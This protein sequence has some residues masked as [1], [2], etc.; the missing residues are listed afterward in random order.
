M[1]GFSSRMAASGDSGEMEGTMEKRYVDANVLEDLS[2][3]HARAQD[4]LQDLLRTAESGM[5]GAPQGGWDQGAWWEVRTTMGSELSL[6]DQDRWV[7]ADRAGRVRTVAAEG[8][9]P[10]LK[11]LWAAIAGVRQRIE[12]TVA[13]LREFWDNYKR[14]RRR[15]VLPNPLP[16]LQSG[17]GATMG[18]LTGLALTW[19]WKEALGILVPA[20]PQGK[21]PAVQPDDEA[22]EASVITATIKARSVSEGLV[23]WARDQEGKSVDADGYYGPQ[24][25][26]LVKGAVGSLAGGPLTFRGG[27]PTGEWNAFGDTK[28]D[29]IFWDTGVWKKIEASQVREHGGYQ[30][31]DIVFFSGG[32]WDPAGHIGIVVEFEG[33]AL[34]VLEQNHDVQMVEQYTYEKSWGG[35]STVDGVIRYDPN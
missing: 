16:W 13:W 6:L 20:P 2:R 32:N 33:G 3:Y 25:V 1:A 14:S 31:G 15:S 29:H 35:W 28:K 23:R 22:E 17:P 11:Q 8:T 7:L 26:D 5:Y 18:F 34:T 19:A 10:W 4:E 30:P 21:A 24:C 27:G 12:S 9:L